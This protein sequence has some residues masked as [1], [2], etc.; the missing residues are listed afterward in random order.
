[1]IE[2]S[3][4]QVEGEKLKHPGKDV[5]KLLLQD[6]K[7]R[8]AHIVEFRDDAAY[9]VVMD[10]TTIEQSEFSKIIKVLNE[11]GIIADGVMV[12]GKPHE[13]MGAYKYELPGNEKTGL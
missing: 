10:R 1:M 7:V 2:E 8:G 9:L 6:L 4:V 12:E 11:R 5:K 3:D 13:V